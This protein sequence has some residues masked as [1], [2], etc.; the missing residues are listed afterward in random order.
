MKRRTFIAGG[1]VLVGASLA[2]AQVRSHRIGLL[3]YDTYETGGGAKLLRA[4]LK[5]LGYDEGVNLRIEERWAGADAAR[6]DQYANDLARLNLDLVV[7]YTNHEIAALRRARAS[8]PIV[9]YYGA[10]PQE[11]GFIKSRA[12][13]G[14]NI[15]GTEYHS[16]ETAAKIVGILKEAMPAARRV[17]TLWNP[18]FPGMRIYG[19][20]VDAA[21]VNAGFSVEYFDALRPD[22]VPPALARIAS[23]KPQAL[24][25]AY[26]SVIGARLDEICR[27]ALERQL[28]S[29][30][31]SV[32]YGWRGGCLAYGPDLT[33]LTD[34]TA[35]YVDRILRGAKPA[36][37][38][39][40]APR[41]FHLVV[42]MATAR[43]IGYKLPESLLARADRIIG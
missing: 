17:A 19:A 37:L 21:A 9:M 22:Q 5:R 40:E 34:R 12:K 38:P 20:A 27:F 39:V 28:V 1:A 7:A 41:T 24:Y 43:S 23:H 18:E 16:H 4:A 2:R 30:G 42:N 25:V 36:A 33:D 11:L 8:L 6:L 13:P 3:A 10:L 14:G 31:S 32:V 29:I 35:S 15:T 26:E